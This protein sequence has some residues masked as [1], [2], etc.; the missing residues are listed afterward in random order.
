MCVCKCV[1]VCVCACVCVC[2]CMF[3]CVYVCCF[4]CIYLLDE[5]AGVAQY[6]SHEVKT[7]K[8]NFSEPG[9]TLI[10]VRCVDVFRFERFSRNV[11]T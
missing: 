10:S 3:V 9:T 2:V 1:C 5:L 7:L 8:T 11:P 4:V 6:N